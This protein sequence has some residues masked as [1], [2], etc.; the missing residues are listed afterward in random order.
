M[1]LSRSRTEGLIVLL[2]L[3]LGFGSNALLAPRT[4]ALVP[5]AT[6]T[7]LHGAVLVS[8][9]GTE[10][11]SAR[12]GDLLAAGDI[13]RTESAAVAE[14]TYSDGSS[15]RVEANADHVVRDLRASDPGA[16]QILARAW[17]VIGE[18]MSGTAR[19]KL[20]GPSSTASVRG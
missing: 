4:V 15:V 13:V 3:A 17:H 9:E 6:F 11:A 1:A 12:E 10:F 7:A 20:G 18:L 5:V 14:I 16:E 8:H 2:A 19:Y